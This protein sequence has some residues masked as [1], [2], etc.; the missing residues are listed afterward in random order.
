MRSDKG[1]AFLLRREGRSYREISDQLG[2]AKSTLSNWFKGVDFSA[3][4]K[5]E[6]T[7]QATKKNRAHLQQLNRTRGIALTVQYELAKKEA[8]QELKRYRNVPLFTSAIGIYWGE[9]DR[10]TKSIIRISNTNAQMLQVWVAFLTRI[11]GVPTEKI[12][13][14]MYLYEDLDETKC[15]RYWSRQLGIKKF[16]KTQV[17]PSRHKT[18][19]LPYGTCNVVVVNTYLKKKLMLWIDQLPEMVLNTVPQKHE[20]R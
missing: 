11:C 3:A 12:A 16:H 6:L 8:L 15:R 1:K 13:L 20:E 18:K 7:K 5:E 14:A 4:I 2:V 19:R 10:A 9:G 17:L